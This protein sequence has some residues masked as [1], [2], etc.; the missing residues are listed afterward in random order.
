M[1]ERMR[2]GEGC[3]KMVVGLMRREGGGF[4]EG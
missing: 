1:G 4:R 2:K 3:R